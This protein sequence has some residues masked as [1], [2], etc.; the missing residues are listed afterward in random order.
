MNTVFMSSKNSKIS[1]PHK[2]L[3]SLTEKKT[4]EKRINILPYQILVFT[5][6]KNINKSNKN[7]RFKLSASTW[8]EEFELPDGS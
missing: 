3:L 7:N 2:L 6:W 1:D 4:W 8:N 5:T